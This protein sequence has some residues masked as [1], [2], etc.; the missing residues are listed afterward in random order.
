VHWDAQVWKEGDTWCQLIGGATETPKQGAA[1]LWK[2]KDLK[3][4]TLQK[5]IAPSI[6]LGG[7]WELPYLVPL[8]GRH[9]LMVGAGNPYWI[10]RYNPEAMEF[11]PET[12]QRDVDTG[13]YYSFNPNMGDDKGPNGSSRRLMHGWATIGRPPAIDGVP[14]WEQAHSIPRVISIRGDRLWQEPVPELQRLRHDHR[15]IAARDLPAGKPVHLPSV[16]GDALE[17]LASFD[18]NSAKRCGLIVRADA[19]AKGTTVWAD[20]GNRFGIETRANTHFLKAG[21]PIELRVF[22]DRGVLE[23][24]CNGVAVTHKCFA[25]AARIEVFAFSEGGDATLTDLE[26]WKMNCIW[27]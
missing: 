4:W 16:R 22:V 20:A 8:D 18:R 6:Q 3:T 25:P 12:P 7:Y 27:K 9:V 17:I 11:T 23:V 14:Y 1:W 19:R 2:S 26:A 15:K 10:G 5:N 21:E 13:D 24:Y